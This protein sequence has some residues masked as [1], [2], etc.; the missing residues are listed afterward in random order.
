MPDIKS[1]GPKSLVI[2]AGTYLAL[3]ERM[4]VVAAFALEKVDF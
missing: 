1:L 4:N 3:F 2:S